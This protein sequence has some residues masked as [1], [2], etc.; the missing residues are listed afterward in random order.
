VGHPDTFCISPF[1]TQKARIAVVSIEG[2][3][4]GSIR[5][6]GQTTKGI[7]AEGGF[8]SVRI[9]HGDAVAIVVILMASDR[10]D[11]IRIANDQS[12]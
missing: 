5:G 3:V 4:A 8:V 7:E 9:V 11:S 1:P 6:V 10:V 2:D 12:E